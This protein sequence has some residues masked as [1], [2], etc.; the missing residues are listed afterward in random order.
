MSEQRISSNEQLGEWEAAR[1]R[2]MARRVE[3]CPFNWP[4]LHN[5]SCFVEFNLLSTQIINLQPGGDW[6]T[7]GIVFTVDFSPNIWESLGEES[8]RNLSSGWTFGTILSSACSFPLISI[9][10]KCPWVSPL[11]QSQ[12]M[13]TVRYQKITAHNRIVS[14]SHSVLWFCSESCLVHNPGIKK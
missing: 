6:Q 5:I 9:W 14:H 11:K 12:Q 1:P 2:R 4:N 10:S 3:N 13:R 7:G 8:Y